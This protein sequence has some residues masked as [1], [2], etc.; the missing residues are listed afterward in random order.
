[1]LTL[2]FPR[3]FTHPLFAAAVPA[4]LAAQSV[5][6]PDAPAAPRAV[7]PRMKALVLGAGQR[8]RLELALGDT[9]FQAFTRQSEVPFVLWPK[10]D[11]PKL[12]KTPA[13]VQRWLKENAA[14]LG[15]ARLEL[16]PA[17]VGAWQG[18][19]VWVYDVF[20]DGIPVFDTQFDVYWD[21]DRLEGL[22][23]NLPLPID[24]IETA[25]A[26]GAGRAGRVYHAERSAS[27]Y[28]L[29]LASVVEEQGSNQG[30]WTR[31]VGPNGTLRTIH[32]APAASTPTDA[33]FTEYVVPS[34]SFPD[35]IDVDAAGNI[36]F[37]QSFIGSLTSFSPSTGQ[38]R[39]H[40]TGGGTPDGL[41]IDPFQ[42]VWTGLYDS[43]AGL[44]LYDIASG[45]FQSFAP[46][47]PGANLAIPFFS[48]S[49][50]LFVTDHA[51]N[52][53]SQ[54]DP[55]QQVW[56]QS[57][58]MPT[59]NCWVVQ[60]SEDVAGQALYCTEF[61]VDQLAR[62]PWDGPI[63][64]IAVPPGAGPAFCV[65]SRG[66]VY[67]S[68]WNRGRLGRYEIS[69][70]QVV[71]FDL[72]ALPF[73]LGGPID[74]TPAG[75]IALGTR[76]VGYIALFD[77]STQQFALHAIPTPGSGLKDGL[78]V[79]PAGDVWFTESFIGKLGVLDLP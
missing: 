63:T 30:R 34:S 44:G 35:Q 28:A 24:T 12:D 32:S 20:V 47:Y 72:P 39:L 65:V 78:V 1:M 67:Y 52:R 17:G 29:S 16:R 76:S 25:P 66:F 5:L 15:H 57:E 8:Q 59:P 7:P 19:E 73:E 2:R 50:R 22:R 48:R 79:D 58:V 9:T 41:W 45:Q 71:E 18:A 43:G 3:A 38:F 77:P 40:P 68:E 62:K 53:L 46:P 70:G 13:S 61:N 37:S 33:S 55:L 21:G 27:G 75:Q 64:D 54:F 31:L 6:P 36:W 4:L 60:G 10:E 26:E 51:Q 74:A 11:A 49:G 56:I 23:N 42:R 14:A 69:S